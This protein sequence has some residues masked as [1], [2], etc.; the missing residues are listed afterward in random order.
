VHDVMKCIKRDCI[1]YRSYFVSDVRLIT[2]R[3]RSHGEVN[4]PSFIGMRLMENTKNFS[5]KWRW[6][7]EDSNRKLP[8]YT[9]EVPAATLWSFMLQ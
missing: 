9:P 5:H 8:E 3:D 4:A 1:S 2:Q 6:S 7:G